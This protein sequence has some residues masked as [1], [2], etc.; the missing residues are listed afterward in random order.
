MPF[1]GILRS[2]CNADLLFVN[3]IIIMCHMFF[4]LHQDLLLHIRHQDFFPH[5][6][7]TDWEQL[8]KADVKMVFAT[9]YPFSSEEAFLD[10][11]NNIL[12]EEEMD[13]YHKECDTVENCWHVIRDVT[14]IKAIRTSPKRRG[15][16]LH[17]EG[18]NCFRGKKDEW[19]TLER[20]Y[21]KGWRSLGVMWNKTNH[22]GGGTE[23]LQTP[24]SSLG[25][26]V[27]QWCLDRGMVIDLAH[28]NEPTFAKSAKILETR[29]KPLF[30]SHAGARS[31][32]DN[33]RNVSDAQLR[34]VAESDGT[35]G[36]FFSPRFL[37]QEE[38]IDSDRIVKHIQHCVDVAGEDH[39]SI[40]TDFGGLV[41][42][43]PV[44]IPWISSLPVLER[45]LLK[46]FAPNQVEKICFSN[47]QRVVERFLA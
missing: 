23:D 29:E 47:A 22:L 15:I 10:P 20:W 40:G 37:G 18:L 28:M 12:I 19:D 46:V 16:V 26:E 25:E 17:V 11:K 4:D 31:I 35:V 3:S 8:E 42:G 21:Q 32:Y 14:D 44:D 38:K 36:I 24:L 39:V 43:V 30:V 5:K 13:L 1:F 6:K 27:I 9:A 45:K 41:S 33:R 7:Q 2:A 34:R